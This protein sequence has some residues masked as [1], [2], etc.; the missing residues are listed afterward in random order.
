[1]SWT[2]VIVDEKGCDELTGILER[3]LN[4]VLEVQKRSNDRLIAAD[5]AGISFTVSILGYPSA[6][7]KRK[8]G[9]PIDAKQLSKSSDKRKAKAKRSEK[10]PGKGRSTKA[11]RKTKRKNASK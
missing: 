9:P 4:G 10:Q 5:A 3:A 7:E 6:N 8:V 1:M 11:T 2:P